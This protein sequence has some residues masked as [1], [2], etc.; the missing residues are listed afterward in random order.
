[1]TRA[2][3]LHLKN[4]AF[5][6]DPGPL[7][8]GCACYT[9][10]RFTRA[11]LRHLVV[12]REILGAVL[13]TIHNVHLLLTLMREM[14]AAILEDRFDA[15]AADFLAHYPAGASELPGDG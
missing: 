12:A 14:R 9:C 6:R 2:G 7:E 10:A 5:A 4:A 11:Y 13:L 15:Y 3:R 8:P 1:M